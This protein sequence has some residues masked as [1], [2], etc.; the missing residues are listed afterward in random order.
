[1]ATEAV[2]GAL[3]FL[4]NF[5]N[6]EIFANYLVGNNASRNVLMKTGFKVFGKEEIFSIFYNKKVPCIKM[7]YYYNNKI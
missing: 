7:K 2:N 1:M 3:K 5:K 4:N 6:I